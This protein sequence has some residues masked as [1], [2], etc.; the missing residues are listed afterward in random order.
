MILIR[1]IVEH[2]FTTGCLT[3]E[4]EEQLRQLLQKKYDAN[5]LKAFMLLQQAAMSGSVKQ[6][7]REQALY[8]CAA[9]KRI[10]S[11]RAILS[12]GL[13]DRTTATRSKA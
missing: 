10:A 2:A 9:S 6:E 13:A 3:V 11:D 7:S 12:C 5:D 4:A 8:E 1:E